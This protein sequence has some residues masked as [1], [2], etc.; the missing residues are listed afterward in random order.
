MFFSLGLIFTIT[1]VSV[2]AD[3]SED[4]LTI[5]NTLHHDIYRFY[6]D[7][8]RYD[9][10]YKTESSDTVIFMN[11]LSDDASILIDI[12]ESQDDISF[13]MDLSFALFKN[14]N[15][16]Y[17]FVLADGKEI[18]CEKSLHQ[19]YSHLKFL[20]PQ[21]TQQLEIVRPFIPEF[22]LPKSLQIIHNPPYSYILPPLK[23]IKNGIDFNDVHCSGDL[24]LIFKPNYGGVACVKDGSTEKLAERN[25]IESPFNNEILDGPGP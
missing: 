13:E 12:N 23:Q 21:N 22:D 19:S 6:T 3:D 25:W 8:V 20:I 16:K 9:I 1:S 15:G 5:E 18:E 17:C 14:T 11:I 7:Y 4:H 24:D 10:P 2:Y